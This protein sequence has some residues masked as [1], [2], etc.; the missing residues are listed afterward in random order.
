[1]FRWINY[2][3]TF[4]EGSRRVGRRPL[5]QRPQESVYAVSWCGPFYGRHSIRTVP[6]EL[7]NH[8]IRHSQN[9][10]ML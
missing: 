2:R 4:R 9:F 6:L 1:M 7:G 5:D 3:L 10:R 8:T